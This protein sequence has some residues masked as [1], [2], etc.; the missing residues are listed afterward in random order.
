MSNRKQNGSYDKRSAD[1][2]L[3]VAAK[4]LGSDPETLRKQ[5]QSGNYDSAVS[6]LSG[7]DQQ[8]LQR[9][10]SD[11]ELTAKVLNS[12]RAQEIFRKLSGK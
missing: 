12:P 9:A 4:K 1:K 3:G 10:L 2:L 7:K 8:L 6:S 5:F 11:P